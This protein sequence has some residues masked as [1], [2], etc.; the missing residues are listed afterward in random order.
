MPISHRVFISVFLQLQSPNNRL[1]KNAKQQVLWTDE[2]CK[3][4]QAEINKS[5]DI[6]LQ[7]Q[8]NNQLLQKVKERTVDIAKMNADLKIS[9]R[10]WF[11]T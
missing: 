2:L 5:K 8:L 4:L 1:V 10:I 9:N 6:E 11:C 7:L 3:Q